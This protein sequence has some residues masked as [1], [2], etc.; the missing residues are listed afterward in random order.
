MTGERNAQIIKLW[1]EGLSARAVAEQVGVSQPLVSS[2]IL[3]R[4]ASGE[5][6]RPKVSGP[7]NEE[8][9]ARIVMLWNDGLSSKEIADRIGVTKN[10]VLAAIVKHRAL[11]DITRSMVY[12]RS[13]R[14]RLGI[15][16]RFG[17]RRKRK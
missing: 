13:D 12:S 5:I 2:L 17:F 14:G 10:V 1:N 3:R 15:I 4:R 7:R 11:G 6:T 16:A 9:N 8:R